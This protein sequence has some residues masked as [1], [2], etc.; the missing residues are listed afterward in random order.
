MKIKTNPFQ[1]RQRGDDTVEV[2][3]GEPGQSESE[4]VC[5]VHIQLVPKLI[6]ALRQVSN[7]S[8]AKIIAGGTQVK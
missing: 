4:F 3:E 8:Q 7:I 6:A 5:A 1:I 2:W